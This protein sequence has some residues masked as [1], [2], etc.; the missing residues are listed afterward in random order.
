MLQMCV[1]IKKY[2]IKRLFRNINNS[3]KLYQQYYNRCIYEL[4]RYEINNIFNGRRQE[5]SFL[6]VFGDII[7]QEKVNYYVLK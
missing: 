1:K 6:D 5:K 4:V 7:G 3:N 2:I